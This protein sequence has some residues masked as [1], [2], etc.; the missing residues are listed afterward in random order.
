MQTNQLTRPNSKRISRRV[1]RGSTRGKTSGRGTKGQKARAGHRIRPI[2]RD[3]IK[4]IPK[5]RGY[6]KNRSRT[7]NSSVVKPTVVTLGTLAMHFESGETVTPLLLRQRGI[8]RRIGGRDPKVKIVASGVCDK[9]LTI[10]K[11][12]VSVSVRTL[13][14]QAGGRVSA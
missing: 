6:G 14:E 13:I 8:V 4:K 11:C 9:A 10:S 3:I 7:V 1:G 12:E 2:M 5:R